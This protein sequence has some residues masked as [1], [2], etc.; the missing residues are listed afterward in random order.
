MVERSMTVQV[1]NGLEV[2]PIAMLVQIAGRF[3]SEIHIISGS[4]K[5]NAKSIMGLMALGIDNGEEI[6]VTANGQDENEALNAIEEY[7]TK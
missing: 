3:S 2:R 7:L 5:I 6:V 1:D 4:R